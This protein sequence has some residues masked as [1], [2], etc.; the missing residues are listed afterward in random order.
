LAGYIANMEEKRNAYRVL[1][2]KQEGRRPLEI[3]R[4]RWENNIKM[5]LREIGW[6]GMDWIYLAQDRDQWRVLMNTVMILRVA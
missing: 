6:G 5:G 4:Y 1:V 2:G 3:P